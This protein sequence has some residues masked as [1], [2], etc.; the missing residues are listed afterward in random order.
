MELH[1]I[2]R[3]RTRSLKRAD[4][5]FWSES[6]LRAFEL[7]KVVCRP[8]ATVGVKSVSDV[9]LVAWVSQLTWLGV[10]F[11]IMSS[12]VVT[13]LLS[14]EIAVSSFGISVS[15]VIPSEPARGRPV[16]TLPAFYKQACRSPFIL[17]LIW[18]LQCNVRW[19]AACDPV[20]V[21][22][23]LSGL[24]PFREPLS[25]LVGEIEL[26][27][28]GKGRLGSGAIKPSVR[29]FC[30]LKWRTGLGRGVL[31]TGGVYLPTLPQATAQDGIRQVMVN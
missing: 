22:V 26:P 5:V 17:L 23:C 11:L 19:Q 13:F 25:C 2:L 21:A 1:L 28:E 14:C 16:A 12:L 27:V 6:G 9:G 3:T 31:A 29:V 30:L 10:R 20:P 4:E 24:W 15:F 18:Q 7:F 8:N